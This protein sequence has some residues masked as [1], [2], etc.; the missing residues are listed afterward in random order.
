MNHK[1]QDFIAGLVAGSVGIIASQPLDVGKV[2]IQ[3]NPEYSSNIFK[4]ISKMVGEE[5]VRSL[6]KGMISP[7]IGFGMVNC[8]LFGVEGNLVKHYMNKR[9][10]YSKDYLSI[11]D[12]FR[13]GTISGLVQCLVSSPSELIK[14]QI[15]VKKLGDTSN[16]K[17]IKEI[18]KTTG[19]KGYFRG[20]TSTILRDMPSYGVYFASFEYLQRYFRKNNKSN[21]ITTFI[22]GGLAGVF[23]WISTYP[24]DIIKTQIQSQPLVKGKFMTT[25][26]FVKQMY[27]KDGIG[28]F[29]R[30]LNSALLRSF[31]L[32]GVTFLVHDLIMKTFEKNNHKKYDL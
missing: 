29:A 27:R 10:V 11:T 23:A 1:H 24:F 2:I 18:Y 5:G 9:N 14:I 21:I 20:M 15:Q 3:G 26:S 22:S 16:M 19:I 7:L 32:N 4:A 30:G 8:F 25:G 31:P 6:Y 28:I 13:C 12:I 17:L